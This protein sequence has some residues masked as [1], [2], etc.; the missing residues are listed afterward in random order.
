M[1]GK[2]APPPAE[3]APE[4]DELARAI[5]LSSAAGALRT[6]E[7]FYPDRVEVLPQALASADDYRSTDMQTTWR[8]AL[9]AATDIW[10]LAFGGSQGRLADDYA[11]RTGFE[12]TWHEGSMTSKNPRMSGMRSVTDKGRTFD[13]S[14]HVK[15]RGKDRLRMHFAID[16]DA[17]KVVI[18]HFGTHMETVGSR[19]RGYK[20]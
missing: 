18:G 9:S 3:A 17:R 11:A 13:I 20:R 6:L 19:K 14:A 5:D 12:L 1:S 10:P 7:A 8:I 16:R 2:A 15:G 4:R